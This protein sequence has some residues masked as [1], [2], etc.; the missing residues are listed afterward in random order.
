MKTLHRAAVVAFVLALALPLGLLAAGEGRIV[1]TVV[2]DDNQPLPDATVLLTRPGTTYKI[3]KKTDKK[4]QVM[5]LVLDATQE[6]ALHAEKPGYGIYDGPIKPQLGDTMRITL[7]IFKLKE[8]Q[9]TATVPPE[10]KGKND[11]I[12]AYNEAVD[13]LHKND[14]AAAV[15]PLQKAVGLDPQLAEARALLTEVL[16]ELKR[17]DEALASADAYLA[18]KPG[19]ERALRDRFDA[20]KGKGDAALSKQAL[21]ALIAASP[22][23]E[24]TAVRLY[25]EGAALTRNGDY[26]NAAP[27]FEVVTRI[28]PDKKEF[29]KAHYVLALA[30]A[31]DEKKHE[32]AREHIEKFLAIAPD[33]PDAK[34]AQEMLAY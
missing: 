34:A 25:N 7:Q 18:L 13:A 9:P 15:A 19:D 33:D 12:L 21:A 31:K 11:A 26:D 32:A 1:A 24:E 30:Y 4:G 2:D 10:L 16:L 8:A 23:E 14:F 17:N 6:Y 5:L 3:E 28:A 29:A 22:K 20:A 27:L